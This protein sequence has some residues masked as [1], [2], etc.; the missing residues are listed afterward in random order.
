[1]KKEER[2][3]LGKVFKKDLYG[4]TL[5]VNAYG[6]IVEVQGSLEDS[7]T[8][9]R[10]YWN[11]QVRFVRVSNYSTILM[12]TSEYLVLVTIVLR[13]CTIIKTKLM[14]NI[15]RRRTYLSSTKDCFYGE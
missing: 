4:D 6:I 15:R 10:M 5:P 13:A 2:K 1:M 12:S 3:S 9:L 11:D 14:C 8:G 7:P